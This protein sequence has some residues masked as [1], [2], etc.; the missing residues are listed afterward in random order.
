MIA[1]HSMEQ[2]TASGDGIEIITNEPCLDE[3]HGNGRFTEKRIYLSRY[4]YFKTISLSIHLYPFI[5]LGDCLLGYKQFALV[6]STLLRNHGIFIHLL[7]QV[8]LLFLFWYS[9]YLFNEIKLCFMFY[10]SYSP[11]VYGKLIYFFLS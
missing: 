5:F 2:S 4:D 7:K 10:I 11:R 8:C 1:R 9:I 3:K 6:S